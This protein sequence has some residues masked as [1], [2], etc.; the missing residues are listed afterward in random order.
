MCS[1]EVGKQAKS[2]YAKNWGKSKRSVELVAVEQAQKSL[3]L[4]PQF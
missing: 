1:V 3:P 2:E 4:K